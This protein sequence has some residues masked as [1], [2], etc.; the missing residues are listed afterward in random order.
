MVANYLK[1]AIR[2]LMRNKTFSAINILGLAIGMACCMLILL[3]VQD[4]LSYDR[5]HEN[6]DRIFRLAA[7]INSEGAP[8]RFAVTSFPMGST[9]VQEYPSV[10]DAVR[11]HRKDEKTLVANQQRHFYERGVLFV[12]S[13]VFQGIRFSTAQR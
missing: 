6:A 8:G 13:N 11:F 5:H 9:L 2:N 1:V 10:E 7:E 4:E 12:D 3:Y